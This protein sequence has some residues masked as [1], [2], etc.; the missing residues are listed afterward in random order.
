M[1]LCRA[2]AGRG[3][4]PG[5]PQTRC[6]RDHIQWM[7]HSCWPKLWEGATST[8]NPVLRHVRVAREEPPLRYWFSPS[9]WPRFS[10]S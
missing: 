9:R 8:W 7:T 3:S 2:P 6:D 1:I 4:Q 10:S 5:T